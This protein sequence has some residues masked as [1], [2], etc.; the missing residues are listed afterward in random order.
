[1]RRTAARIGLVA[2]LALSM[3]VAAVNAP[4]ARAEEPG[5][6][7]APRADND[8]MNYAI[9][10]AGTDPEDLQRALA[11]VPGAGGAALASYP[12]I[13][14]FFAQS[15]TPLFAPDLA[16]ALRQAGIA[17]HSIGPTRV[18][19]VLYYERVELP[20]DKKDDA[21]APQSG[22]AGGLT[23]MRDET[24]SAAPAGANEEVFNWGAVAMHAREAEA[25]NVKRAPVTVAV[26]DSGVEDTHPDLE[27]RVDTSRSVKCS[28]NGVA[29]QDFYGWRDEF[30]HGTHVAGIIAAKHNDIGIDGIAPEASIVAIE[31]TND[32]RLIYPEYVTCAFMWAAS[33][34]VDVVNNSYSMDPWVYW[35]PTDP[36]QA[37]GLEAAARS[38]KYA[39]DKGL[40]VI[41]AA[42][43]E[44]VDIDNPTIDNGSPT[45]V[46]TPTKNRAVNGGIR[47]PSM[48]DGVAQVSAVGQAYNVKPGLSLGRAEFS[49]YGNTIDFAAPGDQIYSTVPLLFYPSGYAVADGT[50]MAT[51]HV[52]GIAALIKSVHPELSGAQVIDLMKKQA[53]AN[54]GRLNAPIDGREYRGY[55][56]LDAL[57]A[58][59]SGVDQ[60]DEAKAG[61]WV[62]DAVGWWYRYEDGSYPA[63]MSAQIDGATYRFDA[64]GYM[65]TGWA[66]EGGQWFYHGASGA[67]VAGWANVNGTWYYLDPASGAM[68]T[69]WVF[70]SGTWYYLG[71]SGAMA[72]GWAYVDGAWYYLT[73]SGAMA[74]GWLHEGGSWYYL[75]PATGAMVTGSQQVNGVAYTFGPDGRMR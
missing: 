1:M 55:G 18:A 61:A 9:N 65:V 36:E 33:H 72:T 3:G 47:V 74:I 48:L 28:V 49:N 60:I 69:G 44:G 26:V 15:A 50:S 23:S 40:A 34:G 29:T 13:G 31:A 12:E 17:I 11:L 68:A 70:V 62:K 56:F 64:R 8:E 71:A 52:S 30:Y 46:P 73:P 63:S 66:L 10:L 39:Q 7:S 25:V 6:V 45:D 38:I 14:T 21:P 58:V 32:N 51:P 59:T 5:L 24:A 54:Y 42:G 16:A 57:D 22:A 27:G 37:A 41:A 43:N 19:P 67:Q 53:A 2:A 4:S 35:S 75:D 20:T